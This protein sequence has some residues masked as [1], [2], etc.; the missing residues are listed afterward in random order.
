MPGTPGFAGHPGTVDKGW[1]MA[2]MLAMA[3]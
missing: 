1:L 3:A 2:H